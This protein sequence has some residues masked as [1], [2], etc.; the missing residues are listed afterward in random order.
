MENFR[1]ELDP[2]LYGPASDRMT[3][4]MRRDIATT[5]K[6]LRRVE[7]DLA[8]TRHELAKE[9]EN[10]EKCRRREQLARGIDDHETARIAVEYA[11]RHAERAAVLR[12]KADALNAERDLLRRDLDAMLATLDQV[13][14]GN[15]LPPHQDYDHQF[16]STAVDPEADG[17]EAD[18]DRLEQQAR[19][20]AAEARLEELKRKLD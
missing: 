18:F 15:D 8:A 16:D 11:E 1:R 7:R 12:R 5:R 6:S 3:D 9:L 4:A 20:R 19:E 10:E 2:D 13:D 14:P 17:I